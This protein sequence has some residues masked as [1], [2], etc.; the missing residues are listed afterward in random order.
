MTH[1]TQAISLNKQK[2][3][4]VGEEEEEVVEVILSLGI[5]S[6]FDAVL[7]DETNLKKLRGFL[8]YGFLEEKYLCTCVLL[9]LS[10]FQFKYLT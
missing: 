3:K 5:L 4:C 9:C 2:D 8:L 6:W 1:N 7:S 10:I